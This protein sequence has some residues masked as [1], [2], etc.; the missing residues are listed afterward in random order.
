MVLRNL[1]MRLKTCLEDMI[2][3]Q[4]AKPEIEKV[5]IDLDLLINPKSYLKQAERIRNELSNMADPDAIVVIAAMDR[6]C[7]ETT[8]EVKKNY[9]PETAERLCYEISKLRKGIGMDQRKRRSSS[10][11]RPPLTR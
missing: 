4:L 6:V 9:P 10:N 5:P 7:K 1:D 8:A 11:G 3:Y 2:Q